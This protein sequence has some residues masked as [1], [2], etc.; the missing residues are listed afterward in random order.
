MRRWAAC[1]VLLLFV[2]AAGGCGIPRPKQPTHKPDRLPVAATIFPLADLVRNIGGDLVEVT[3]LLGPGASPH[4]YEPTAGQ[5]KRLATA[6]VVVSVGSGLDDWAAGLAA[7][8][9]AIRLVLARELDLPAGADPHVWLDPVLVRDRIAPALARVL[10]AADPGHAADYERNLAAYAAALTGLDREIASRT[11]AFGQR[12]FVSFHSAWRHFAD[13]YGLEEA[14]TIEEYPG[15]EPSP[16]W[17]ADTV[18]VA[19]QAG[20]KAIFAEPQF[21]TRAAEVI[22]AEID[23]RVL[24]LDPLGGEGIPGRDTYLGLM[25]YNLDILEQALGK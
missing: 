20:V 14:A 23:V 22:A 5:V 2:L 1:A 11:A 9:D 13:R 18:A 25:R 3:T 12:R 7:G 15:K 10:A 21:S 8:T 24:I 16:R 17:L 6:R 19:R 4:T